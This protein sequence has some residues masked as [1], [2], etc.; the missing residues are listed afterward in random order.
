MR[1][2]KKSGLSQVYAHRTLG[3]PQKF[4]AAGRYF[5]GSFIRF[6][7]TAKAAILPFLMRIFEAKQTGHGIWYFTWKKQDAGAGSGKQQ[8]GADR[9]RK[10]TV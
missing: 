2:G 10:A 8:Y 7:T 1:Q 9:C 3:A 6:C 4:A 5:K